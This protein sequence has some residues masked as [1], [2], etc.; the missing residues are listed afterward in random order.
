MKMRYKKLVGIFSILI[1]VLEVCAFL[2]IGI[3]YSPISVLIPGIVAILLGVL[4][5]QRTYFIVNNDSLVFHALLGSAKRTYKFLSLKELEIENNN[6]FM[7]ITGK[8]KR[9]ISG[10]WVENN[11]W[12]AF[13][14]K[15][16]SAS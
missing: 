3:G 10:W 11:D 16:N 2:L 15:I 9:I 7:T 1:G 14:Q 13:L 5:L 8:R 4:F 6:I 12:H